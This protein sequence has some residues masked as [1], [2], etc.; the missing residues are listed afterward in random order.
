M[1]ESEFRDWIRGQLRALDERVKT[2]AAQAAV[3]PPPQVGG[4]LAGGQVRMV[5]QALE[6]VKTG[7]VIGLAMVYLGP[8]GP[9]DGWSCSGGI[10]A[11]LALIGAV[12]SLNDDLLHPG[13]DPRYE[14]LV[15][16]ANA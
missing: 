2:L 11:H 3:Q 5:E 7:Q 13:S 9:I 4:R 12:Q 15:E 8:E 10:E 16:E 1:N 14:A 6:A